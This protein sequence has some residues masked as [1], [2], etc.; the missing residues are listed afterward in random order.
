MI[1]DMKTKE[2]L[3]H[4]RFGRNDRKNTLK[5][6]VMFTTTL[7]FFLN[8]ETLYNPSVLL[9]PSIGMRS[10]K[11]RI[12]SGSNQNANFQ[13]PIIRRDIN[14]VIT[15]YSAINFKVFNN[16]LFIV[17]TSIVHLLVF[18]NIFH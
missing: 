4:F 2:F 8:S 10:S 1:D 15:K 9:N 3:N 13:R 12:W 7:M 5:I 17:L 14:A 16:A 6:K 11:K 18:P